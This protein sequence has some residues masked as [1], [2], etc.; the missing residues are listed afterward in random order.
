M[1]PSKPLGIDPLVDC[2]FK[3]L[4]GH[5]DN[6]NLL[7]DFLNSVLSPETPIKAVSV[8]NPYNDKEYLS[9]KYSIVDVKAVDEAGGKYQIEVQLST[10][11]C[12][13]KRMLYSWSSVYK[14]QMTKGQDNNKLRPVIAIWLLT[15]GNFSELDNHHLEFRL[16]ERQHGTILTDDIQIHVLQLNRWHKP[17]RLL[18]ADYWLYFLKEAKCWHHIP[19]MMQQVNWLEQAMKVLQ[20]FS[21]RERDILLY[22]SRLD[23]LSIQIS[24]DKERERLLE[25]TKL[26]K[27]EHERLLQ[28]A[29]LNKKAHEQ[30]QHEL[31]QSQHT[32][33]QERAL[34]QA[35]LEEIEKLKAQLAK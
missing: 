31:Q 4:F 3:A 17:Q 33:E 26:D 21:E 18:Q 19:S 9:D 20:G 1:S 24:E 8:L 7:I 2:V 30:S 12:L 22:E 34:K 15:T 5:P 23:A 16:T 11:S 32:L 27:K 6:D 35:A 10:P 25:Q 14:S 28:Q 13:P 29:E